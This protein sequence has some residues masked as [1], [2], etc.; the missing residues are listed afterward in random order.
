MALTRAVACTDTPPDPRHR[1]RRRGSYRKALGS[2]ML[3]MAACGCD[4]FSRKFGSTGTTRL[5]TASTAEAPRPTHAS[6]NACV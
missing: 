1:F 2:P 3:T 5:G 6:P 4:G